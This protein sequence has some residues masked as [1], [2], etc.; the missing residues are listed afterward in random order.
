MAVLDSGRSVWQ[1]AIK[2]WNIQAALDRPGTTKESKQEKKKEKKKRKGKGHKDMDVLQTPR[3]IWT[4]AIQGHQSETQDNGKFGRH[5]TQVGDLLG[6]QLLD[7]S[8]GFFSGDIGG[9]G[10]WSFQGGLLP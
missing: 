10:Q 9:S 8:Y 2:T 6:S 7:K 4:L 1:P 3:R 5:F